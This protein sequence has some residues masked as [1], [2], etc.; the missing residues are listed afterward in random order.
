MKILIKIT[1]I[2]YKL[3]ERCLK[4]VDQMLKMPRLLKLIVKLK[5]SMKYPY[6]GYPKTILALRM[7]IIIG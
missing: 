1:R 7:S 3:K 6:L 5:F 4:E 2:C